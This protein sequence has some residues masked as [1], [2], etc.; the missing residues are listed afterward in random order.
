MISTEAYA[1]IRQSRKNGLSMRETARKLGMSR[2]T[3]KRYWDGAHT[4]D[5]KKKLSGASPVP[6]KRINYGS[7]R[8]IFPGKQKRR[9]AAR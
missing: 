1:S 9:Q 5:E 2:N 4:P 8:K 7:A 3:I 6:A